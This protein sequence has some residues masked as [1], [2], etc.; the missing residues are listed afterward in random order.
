MIFADFSVGS[1]ETA[2]II[3]K[4][5]TWYRW[6]NEFWWPSWN[7]AVGR[8]HV[9]LSVC[10]FNE[11]G[12]LFCQQLLGFLYML[13]IVSPSLNVGEIQWKSL[14]HSRRRQTKVMRIVRDIQSFLLVERVPGEVSSPSRFFTKN[15]NST[16]VW[17]LYL[18][19]N[20]WTSTWTVAD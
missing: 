7:I 6:T 20:G 19:I 1:Q 16:D 3:Q 12:Q 17:S 15:W 4:R 2:K 13:S 8:C 14:S 11:S 9:L 18:F 5:F 10:Y